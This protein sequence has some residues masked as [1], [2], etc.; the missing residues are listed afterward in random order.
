MNGNLIPIS[1]SG[2][3]KSISDDD[4]CAGC[5]HCRYE[6][7]DMSACDRGWPG[8]EDLDGYVQQC[9]AVE[10]AEGATCSECGGE[11]SSVVGSPDGA[12]VCPPCF[13]KGLH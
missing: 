9:E 12:E 7:G 5:T 8:L 1:S 10:P 6:P 3:L 2:V 4:L 13:D 11:V